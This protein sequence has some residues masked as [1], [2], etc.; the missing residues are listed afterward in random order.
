MTSDD[1]F[2]EAHGLLT[3]QSYLE[4]F[5]M[6]QELSRDSYLPADHFLAWMYEQGLGTEKDDEKAFE[7][8]MFSA[9][10]GDGVSQCGVGMYYLKG[11][12]VEQ[13]LVQAYCWFSLSA[14]CAEED[15][16]SECGAKA[17]LKKLERILTKEQLSE[18]QQLL[19]P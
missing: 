14:K 10:A 17:E 19:R 1:K 15:P 9:Q 5:D 4:A 12:I 8:Y 3:K 6:F 2:L 13:N 11:N 18:A 16:D 7:Y